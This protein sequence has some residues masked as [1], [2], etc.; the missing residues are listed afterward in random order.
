MD[1]EG[2]FGGQDQD[3]DKQK[4]VLPLPVPDMAIRQGSDSLAMKCGSRTSLSKMCGIKRN[5]YGYGY[6]SA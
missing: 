5:L 2:V 3:Q 6:G 4:R 1:V